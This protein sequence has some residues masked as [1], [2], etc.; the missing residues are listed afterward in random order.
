MAKK[1][2]KTGFQ[3][4]EYLDPRDDDHVFDD[5][6]AACD[7]ARRLSVRTSDVVFAVYVVGPESPA[8]LVGIW[9]NGI[10]FAR[11]A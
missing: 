3:V 6:G 11:A 8:Q 2:I 4:G 5:R 10:Q 7:V 1:H 9:I